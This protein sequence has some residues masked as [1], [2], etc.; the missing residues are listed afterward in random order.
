MTKA[1]VSS[2]AGDVVKGGTQNTITD[3]IK[4]FFGIGKD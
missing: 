4:V 1:A 3:K 2:P